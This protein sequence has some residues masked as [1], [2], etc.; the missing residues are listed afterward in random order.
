[1]LL[2]KKRIVLG[3]QITDVCC[4]ITSQRVCGVHN[5]GE[6]MNGT[7]IR[8]RDTCWEINV[9]FLPM[10]PVWQYFEHHCCFLFILRSFE[11]L[12]TLSLFSNLYHP[13]HPLSIVLISCLQQ[14][15]HHFHLVVATHQK[16]SSSSRSWKFPFLHP[17]LL[18]LGLV[19]PPGSTIALFL[20]SFPISLPAG[21]IKR[22][23]SAVCGFPLF[24]IP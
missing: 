4:H 19:Y 9:S 14:T 24:W 2:V 16:P 15:Y 23:S 3:G 7:T 6:I 21:I 5:K 10:S 17:S 12:F 1:M 13:L 20:Y 11:V 18:P 8:S 22:T